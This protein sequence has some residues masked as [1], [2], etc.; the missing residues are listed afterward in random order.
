LGEKKKEIEENKKEREKL[1]GAFVFSP[2]LDI[3][4]WLCCTGF[5]CL[6]GAIK[7]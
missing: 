2:G 4:C 5:L 3:P 1:P 6:L 7:G